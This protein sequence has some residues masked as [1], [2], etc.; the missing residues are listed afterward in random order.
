MTKKSLL[1]S[2]FALAAA[3]AFCGAI[4]MD[5][6]SPAA[7][8]PNALSSDPGTRVHDALLN[9]PAVPSVAPAGYDVTVVVFSDYQCPYCRKLHPALKGLLHNDGKVRVVYRDWPIFGGPSIEAA[10][11][12]IASRYQGKHAAF[13]DALM[14]IKGKLTS[15]G[16]R[17]AALKAGVDWKRLQ[18]DLVKHKTEIDGALARTDQFARAMGLSGTPGLVIGAYLF[19]GALSEQNLQRAVQMARQHLPS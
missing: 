8:E 4:Y 3:V 16:I 19:P 10:R 9:D 2:L 13:D 5:S 12:A 7:A 17:T 11:A 18:A 15:D 14:A 1:N 6:G